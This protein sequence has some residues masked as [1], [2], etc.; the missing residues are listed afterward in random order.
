MDMTKANEYLYIIHGTIPELMPSVAY[1]RTGRAALAGRKIIKC[2]YCQEILTD[3][4]R[5]TLVEIYRIPK[6]KLK[7]PSPAQ[8]FKKCAACKAEV[9]LVIK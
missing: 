9:G 2:P 1:R 8:F 3:V 6:R 5:K 4:D 7:K